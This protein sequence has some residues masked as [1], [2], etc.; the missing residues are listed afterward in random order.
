M[1]IDILSFSC[2]LILCSVGALFSEFAGCLALFLDGL[3]SLSAFLTYFFTIHT[4]SLVLGI[5]CSTLICTFLSLLFALII[6]KIKASPFIAS[7]ALNMLFSSLVS[8][9]SSIGFG[10]RGVLT[11]SFFAN[12]IP[13]PTVKVFTLITTVIFIILSFSLL[14]FTNLGIYIRIAGPDSDVLLAKGVNPSYIKM[15]SWGI[16]GLLSSFS[17]TFLVL[18][19]GSFVPNISSGRGWMALAAVFL[20]RKKLWKITICV[21]IFCATDYLGVN[22]QNYFPNIPSSFLL[23]LPYIVAVLLSLI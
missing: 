21:L 3:I 17:G 16:A 10:T 22:I 15:I 8:V 12:V 19:L 2:P 23:S 18:K 1:I 13:L 11:N 5:L 7:L 6:Q 14:R 4:H 9:F 20:G